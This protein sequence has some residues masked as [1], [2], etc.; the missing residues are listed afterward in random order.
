[1]PLIQQ[2]LAVLAILIAAVAA[3]ELAAK[4]RWTRALGAALLAIFVGAL[5]A[6]LRIIPAGDAGG[7]VYSSIIGVVTPAA[8]FL[9]LLEAKLSAVQKIGTPMLI[10]FLLATV[11][12][13]AGIVI[14][15]HVTPARALL[16]PDFAPI[17]GMFAATYVGGAANFNALAVHYGIARQGGLYTAAVVANSIAISLWVMV[18]L[19]MPKLLHRSGLY[20]R[21]KEI[22]AIADAP[23]ASTAKPLTGSAALAAPIALA[24]AALV[25]SNALAAWL[26]RQGLSLPP[27]LIVTTL[28]LIVAQAPG[29]ERLAHAK[30]IGLFAVY[31]FLCVV[32]ANA[33]VGALVAAGGT[34]LALMAFIGVVL[35]VHAAVLLGGGLIFRTE[36]EV[37]A[38]ASNATIGGPS[39]AI[40]LA[41][42]LGR[43]ELALPGLLAG[44]LGAAIGTYVGFA[45]VAII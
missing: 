27:L 32:G 41:E 28:A 29:I 21:A 8:V 17:A 45:I 25:A 3:A 38:M 16:G 12:T 4:W 36:P 39:T 24:L 10:A 11:G 26:Q 6:N 7:P 19:L 9:I 34:G 42:A 15:S 30:V 20:R 31:L 43:Q 5:L 1:M 37:L 23:E 22:P 35:L 13:M 14:A 18:T 2:P 44:T 33:D 40:A